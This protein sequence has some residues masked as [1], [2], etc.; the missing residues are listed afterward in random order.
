MHKFMQKERRVS[1]R[2]KYA[3][4]PSIGKPK[5]SNSQKNQIIQPVP[6]MN[7]FKPTR[8]VVDNFTPINTLR[9]QIL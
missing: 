7:T 8:R 5:S 6:D 4:K 9:G 3:K 2:K 1:L